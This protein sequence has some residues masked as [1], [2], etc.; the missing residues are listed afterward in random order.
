[1]CRLKYIKIGLMMLVLSLAS[2]SKDYLDTEYTTGVGE[3]DLK[4]I[5]KDDPTKLKALV[6]G[7][8]AFMV[9]YQDGGSHD[10]F[11]FT[12]VL[13]ATD[14]MCQDISQPVSHY[15]SWDYLHQYRSAPYIRTAYN[16][17]TFY[18]LI[19]N[20]NRIIDLVD[21]DTEDSFFLNCLGETYTIRGM[22]YL[23]LIQLY[24]EVIT[25][26][27]INWNK[28]G[29]PIYV[30]DGDSI[31]KE[32]REVLKGRNTVEMV[33]K[34]AEQDL[35]LGLKLIDGF[36]R[37]TS[38]RYVNSDVVHGLLARYYLLIQDWDQAAEHSQLARHGYE[39]MSEKELKS[40]FLDLSNNEWIWGFDH[41]NETQTTLVSW[42]S[43][44]SNN[45]PGY[46][47]ILSV[48][49]IDYAL[50]Q[51]IPNDDVRKGLFNSPD[52]MSAEDSVRF[53]SYFETAPN[54]TQELASLKFGWANDW[55]QDYPY[56]RAAEMYLIEAEAYAHKGEYAMAAEAIRPLMENRQPGWDMNEVDVEYVYLQRRIELWGEGFS[57]FDLKRL[58]RGI[59]RN[60]TNSNHS[61]SGQISVPAGAKN[62]VFQIPTREIQD[63][64][65]ISEGEQND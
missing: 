42:F 65:H 45:S 44:I 54:I 9:S 11:N 62:W 63:N 2:C 52:G 51:V 31:S 14:M 13:H 59:N 60:Y 15:F 18:T 4:E 25:K 46:A 28:P 20:A 6:D 23:Y 53:E 64:V 40:G 37:S 8:Y 47:G 43:H 27:T 29:V 21:R 17:N 22:S 7:L 12:A 41:S 57:Y 3:N 30:A 33:L 24:Q 39:L 10:S 35:L 58:Y 49:E 56:M 36:D 55:T 50:Y 34:Q 26:E 32:Q 61:I 48:R 19:A 1:M 38:K 16:W 5:I